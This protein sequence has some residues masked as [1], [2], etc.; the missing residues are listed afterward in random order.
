MVSRQGHIFLL[1]NFLRLCPPVKNIKLFSNIN[2]TI[3]RKTLR[4][5]RQQKVIINTQHRFGF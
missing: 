5:K 3:G 4:E 1:K 2:P